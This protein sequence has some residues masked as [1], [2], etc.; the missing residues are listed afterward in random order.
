MN[1]LARDCARAALGGAAAVGSLLVL[2]MAHGESMET[3]QSPV[4]SGQRQ[5]RG[6]GDD[7]GS[8]V[9]RGR[10][11]DAAQRVTPAAE[12]RAYGGKEPAFAPAAAVTAALLACAEYAAQRPQLMGY[13]GGVRQGDFDSPRVGAVADELLTA[14]HSQRL[15][16]WLLACIARY[17]SGFRCDAVG[18]AGEI[19]LLQIH[20]CHFKEMNELGL[21]PS[22]YGALL[23]RRRLD[24]GYGVW[25][26]LRPWTT[27]RR[28]GGRD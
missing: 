6:P 24:E 7:N 18:Q 22:A 23:I 28:R 17:E 21:G 16:P 10:L 14:A 15:A 20:P 9:E 11:E 8:N 26:A 27:R 4:A 25:G 3:V 13:I 1:R 5:E 12:P 19:G 2:S